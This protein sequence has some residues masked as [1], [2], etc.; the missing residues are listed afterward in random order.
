MSFSWKSSRRFFNGSVS[1]YGTPRGFCA[2]CVA[3]TS[4]GIWIWI[5]FPSRIVPIPVN[6]CSNV[7]SIV[8]V[9]FDVSSS[10]ALR[11]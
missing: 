2:I 6:L 7:S 9:Q 10:C 11:P 4:I 3:L 5:S 8:C 1:W